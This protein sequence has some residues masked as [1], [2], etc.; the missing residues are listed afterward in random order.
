MD[1]VVISR[2]FANL[3]CIVYYQIGFGSWD[4]EPAPFAQIFAVFKGTVHWSTVYD[5]IGE[6]FALALLYL[7][8]TSIHASALK[9]NVANLVYKERVHRTT[10]SSTEDAPRIEEEPATTYDMAT[11]M[12]DALSERIKLVQDSLDPSQP[13]LPRRTM[14]VRSH[15]EIDIEVPLNDTMPKIAENGDLPVEFHETRPPPCRLSLQE[16]FLEY[17][18]TLLV[19]AVVGGFAVCPT[20]SCSNTMYA[21]GAGGPAPQYGCVVLLAFFYLTS[22]SIVRFIPKAVFSSLLVL[23]AVDTFMVW[24]FLSYRKTQSIWEWLVVPFI[25]LLSLI[26]GF[27]NAV[28]VGIGISMF[29]F[30][31]NFFRVGVVKFNATG[32]EIRSTVERSPNLQEWLDTHGDL[33]QVMVLQNYLFFGNASSILAYIS[34]MFEDI[35]DIIEHEGD[36]SDLPP[37]PKVL[38]VDLSL[39]TGMDTS[40]VDIFADIKQLC[41]TNGCKLFL[42]GLSPRDRKGLALG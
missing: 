10:E 36:E 4:E 40:T 32:L 13:K 6:M 23:G 15:S 1:V 8:R 42:C 29:V 22:F 41:K 27:L 31:G 16:I 17:G 33:I 26:V 37:K 21:I 14:R 2:S 39:V 24:F 38:I 19:S 12:A 18:Y 20:I 3:V 34:T 9:K 11:S 25:V 28:I 7:L 30:V 35:I 5:G